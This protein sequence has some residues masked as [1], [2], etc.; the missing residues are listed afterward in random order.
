M[1]YNSTSYFFESR[2]RLLSMN[3]FSSILHYVS[4]PI[5]QYECLIK[6]NTIVFP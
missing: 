4:D 6:G 3:M 2:I 1:K 5:N